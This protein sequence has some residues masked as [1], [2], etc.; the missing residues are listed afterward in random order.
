MKKIYAA[1]LFLMIVVM[2]AAQAPCPVIPAP[3]TATLANSSFTLNKYTRIY[4]VSPSLKDAAVYL[5]QELLKKELL[6][7]GLTTGS[8]ASNAIRLSFSKAAMEG[9]E[10]YTLRIT[11]DAVHI[12]GNSVGGVVNGIASFLQLVRAQ[13]MNN[14]SIAVQGWQIT[15]APRYR[16]RGFMLDESRHFMGKQKVLQLLDWMAF[17]KLNRFHWH[18]TDEP[19]W[20]LEIKRYPKLALLGSVGSF[21]DPVA[22]SAYYTQQDIADVV[23]YAAQR[24]ITVI[25]EIDM[26]GHATAANRAYPEYSG[27]G[28][29]Q[30]P[31]FTFDPG[32]A[33]TYTYLTN[34]LREVNTLFPSGLIHLGGDEVSFGSDKWLQNEGIK[35]LMAQH[36]LKDL[37]AVER[38]FMERMADSVYG[39]GAK[40]LA[41]DEMAE[42]N[43]P[44]AKTIIFW[45]RH[46]KPAQLKMA[47]ERGYDV[48]VCPRL[49]YYFDFVQDSLHRMGR[50]WGKGYSPL[51]D[52]YSYSVASLVNEKQQKQVQGLQANLWTE[53]VTNTT[54]M[55]YLVFPR[56]AALAEA[57]W[58]KDALKN[59]EDFTGRLKKQLPLYRDA[60]IYFY[61]PFDPTEIPEPIYFRKDKRNLS[62]QEN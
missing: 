51:K 32:N 17:Y 3:V 5:Q 9:D 26:P 54:R 20:R 35:K 19:A 24:N 37:K 27:G 8:S 14:G 39:M 40:L 57:A 12:S 31:D 28:N 23:H 1:L 42:V 44:N 55:D 61:N 49:P 59:Y 29:D 47:L 43:L 16:W 50:K 60:D 48:V 21:T 10:G 15:D 34:I 22:A 25:P 2:T 45:W 13:K 53:T 33:R 58:T 11:G 52:V 41:W 4:T 6:P 30:H 36:S 7:L 62:A 46:D 56:I 18:L 38:Y